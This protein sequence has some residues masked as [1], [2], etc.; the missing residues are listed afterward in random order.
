MRDLGFTHYPD[1]EPT[2]RL[3][4][5][6]GYYFYDIGEFR[7]NYSDFISNLQLRQIDVS[8]DLITNEPDE[9]LHRNKILST[10]DLSCTIRYWKDNYNLFT[11][12]TNLYSDMM[13][14]VVKWINRS[15]S[16]YNK[17]DVS[18]GNNSVTIDVKNLIT[19][20]PGDPKRPLSD[21]IQYIAPHLI[22]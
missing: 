15:N 6:T 21:V 20:S 19:V 3:K 17:A 7:H 5:T 22:N 13:G 11:L 16:T 8:L 10:A 2:C 1:I 4:N 9:K 12:E 18:W 14:T